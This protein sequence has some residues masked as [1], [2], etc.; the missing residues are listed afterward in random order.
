MNITYWMSDL[1]PERY[2]DMLGRSPLALHDIGL[3]RQI[4]LCTLELTCYPEEGCAIYLVG[5]A[6]RSREGISP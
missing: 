1:N 4:R 5:D 2:L 3:S 6:Y